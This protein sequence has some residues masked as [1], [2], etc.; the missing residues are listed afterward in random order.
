MITT[1]DSP[2]RPAPRK[3]PLALW[4]TVSVLLAA[5]LLAPTAAASGTSGSGVEEVATEGHTSPPSEQSQPPSEQP[6][7][8]GETQ[9]AAEEPASPVSETAPVSEEPAP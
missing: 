9:H 4:L 2:S 6:P 1:I 8:A 3:G 7:P 5:L